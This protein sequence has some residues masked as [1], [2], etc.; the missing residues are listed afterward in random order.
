[1]S[2]YA[3][4]DCFLKSYSKRLWKALRGK[5]YYLTEMIFK[6]ADV[7]EFAAFL[8]RLTEKAVKEDES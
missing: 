2:C 5:E 4:P 8:N 6:K 7:E 3:K 1:L